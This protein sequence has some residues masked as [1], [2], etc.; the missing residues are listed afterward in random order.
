MSRVCAKCGK[1]ATSG[2]N[3]SHSNIKT[4]RT[5]AANVHKVDIEENG[6]TTKQYLCT[7]CIKTNKKSK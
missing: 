3:V 2:H 1:K 5:F 7:R 4:N 6:K